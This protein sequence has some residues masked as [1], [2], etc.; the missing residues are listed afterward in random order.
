MGINLVNTT[1]SSTSSL[2]PTG[3][4]TNRSLNLS[5]TGSQA[6]VTISTGNT[7]RSIFVIAPNNIQG[8]ILLGEST[9]G[10]NNDKWSESSGYAIKTRG[11]RL[12][13]GIPF[14]SSALTVPK[15]SSDDK[16]V[17]DEYLELDFTPTISFDTTLPFTAPIASIQNS[18]T[19]PTFGN[20][21]GRFI[22]IGKLV[23]FDVTFSISNWHAKRPNWGNGNDGLRPSVRTGTAFR[24]TGLINY[25]NIST[26]ATTNP[27][28]NLTLGGEPN[29]LHIRNLPNHYPALFNPQGATNF[30]V[31][32]T[33]SDSGSP[34]LRGN[35]F[36]YSWGGSNLNGTSTS[37]T[38][39]STSAIWL[40]LDP[41]SI[42]GELTA[43]LPPNSSTALPQ[44]EL[45]GHRRLHYSGTGSIL[46]FTS[47]SQTP[48]QA[49]S[50][51]K[52]K[53]TI[54]DF[55]NQYPGI[56]F[57]VTVSG[58]YITDHQSIQG[59]NPIIPVDPG[60]PV[61]LPN[62]VGTQQG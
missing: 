56:T 17:L 16:N 57:Y 27:F 31:T 32:L 50:P 60:A 1:T 20:A 18:G 52:S 25:G 28:I 21:S 46:G 24:D 26:S 55:L 48:S 22:K 30:K 14:P 15:A 54:W 5:T 44:I 4:T 47:T 58:S 45:F 33:A 11:N 7:G 8:G 40:A 3:F 12:A 10:F 43:Y 19:G 13:A 35:P 9:S 23:H 39:G 49:V 37:G 29:H 61:E 42:H 41:A 59:A 51:V 62:D 6:N 38:S 53:V 36:F 2:T 34:V